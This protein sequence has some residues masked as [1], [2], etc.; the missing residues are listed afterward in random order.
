MDVPELSNNKNDISIYP[1]PS[2]GKYTIEM[3]GHDLVLEHDDIQ[4]YNSLGETIYPPYQMGSPGF[5]ID[6]SSQPAGIYF[7][8]VMSS[9]GYLIGEGKLVIQR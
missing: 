2:T 5:I 8:K 9:Q 4:V 3:A 1:N 7:L 6:L